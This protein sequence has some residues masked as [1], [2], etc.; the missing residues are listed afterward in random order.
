MRLIATVAL[1]AV[2]TITGSV[3]YAQHDAPIDCPLR[4]KGVDPDDLKPF[5][6]VDQYIAFLERPDRAEWQKPDAV[7]AALGLDGTE[8]V[9][10][11]GAGSGYFAFRF[12]DLLPGGTV[13]AIDIEPEMVRHIHHK[14]ATDWVGN[15]EAVLTTPDDPGV[16][17]EVDVVFVCDVLHHVEQRQAWLRQL[18]A[19]M[20]PGARL[21]LIEFEEGDLPEGPPESIKLPKEQLI[22]LVRQAGFRLDAEREE[23]LPYQYFLE[24]SRP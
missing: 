19:Q 20:R 21:V 9:A 24:F 5:A 8:T 1:T 4:E 23:I 22:S 12:A 16:T 3:A 18:H 17:G 14:A 7:V 11:V 6:E 13:R 2:I 10:D 15:V